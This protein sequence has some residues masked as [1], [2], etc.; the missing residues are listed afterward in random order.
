MIDE[1]LQ[2]DFEN[3]LKATASQNF[4]TKV[5]EFSRK[6]EIIKMGNSESLIC[7]RWGLDGVRRLGASPKYPISNL[8]S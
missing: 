3:E 4:P 7:V 6:S 2:L 8:L 5:F 1:G